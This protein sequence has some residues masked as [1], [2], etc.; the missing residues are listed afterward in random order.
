M[1]AAI[2][3]PPLQNL[4]GTVPLEGSWVLGVLLIALLNVAG[5]ELGKYLYRNSQD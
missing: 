3:F 2:Y 4:L 5:V 1:I